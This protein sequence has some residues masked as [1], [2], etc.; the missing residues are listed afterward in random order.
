MIGVG[1]DFPIVPLTFSH[2]GPL[3]VPQLGC[4]FPSSQL[5]IPEEER[6]L[7]GEMSARP[8]LDSWRLTPL[9]VLFCR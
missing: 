8:P 9:V 6:R 1:L 5:S 3:P 7:G 4:S 2:S